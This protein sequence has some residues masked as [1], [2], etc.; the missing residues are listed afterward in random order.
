MLLQQAALKEA[1]RIEAVRQETARHEA[2]RLETERQESAKQ[3][4]AKLA[5]KLAEK[6]AEALKESARQEA[7]RQETIRQE[8]NRQEAARAEAAKIDAERQDA[9]KKA[10]ARQ[11]L[12]RI[13]AARLAALQSDEEKRQENLRAIGQQMKREAAQ[14]EAEAQRQLSAGSLLRRGRLFGRADPNNEL[15]LYAEAWSRK[16]HFNI[17]PDKVQA[18]AR[19][20]RT[21]PVV[22]VAIRSDGS[23]ESVTFVTSSGVPAIDEAIRQIVYSQASYQAFPAKLLKD[24]DVIE[25]R[26][27]WHFDTAI[28][29]D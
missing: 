16:I 25:I 23:V 13:E 15:V 21:N 17:A 14:R 27:T 9:A 12:L 28:R 26:R 1:A 18:I 8:A 2:A 11:E 7:M 29:M 3:A 4:A 20:V 22:T 6:Q 5:A 19:Q 10:A 24:Y